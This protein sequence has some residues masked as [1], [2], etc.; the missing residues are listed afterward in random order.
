V[1]DS[2]ADRTRSGS[3]CACTRPGTPGANEIPHAGSS[4]IVKQLRWFT[5]RIQQPGRLAGKIP[6][7]PEIQSVYRGCA[8]GFTMVDSEN[9]RPP[10]ESGRRD[11]S[12]E[13]GRSVPARRRPPQCLRK[14]G[15]LVGPKLTPQCARV[16][17]CSGLSSH[18]LLH[19]S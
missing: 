14:A 9:P 2:I 19:R 12:P 10:S 5:G 8:N 4:Q 3:G 13:T 7:T 1:I 15:H 6:R 17:P 18:A 11:R 16:Q